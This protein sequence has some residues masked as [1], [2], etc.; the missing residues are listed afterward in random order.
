MAKRIAAIGLL[1][2]LV[3][4]LYINWK[5][6]EQFKHNDFRDRV[7]EWSENEHAILENAYRSLM[8]DGHVPIDM[9]PYE[10][11]ESEAGYIIKFRTLKYLQVGSGPLMYR[12]IYDGCV[13]Y[14][15][16]KQMNL[17]GL[18]NCG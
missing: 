4:S 3:V 12:D 2:I 5:F 13:Y 17:A 1:C 14:K 18:T 11:T 7:P 6:F 9:Y 10:I 16:D 8:E 15:F